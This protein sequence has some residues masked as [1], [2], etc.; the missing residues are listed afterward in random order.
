M[1]EA[2]ELKIT[3]TITGDKQKIAILNLHGY[4]DSNTSPLL[5]ERFLSLDSQTHCFVLDFSDVEYVSSAG[6]GVILGRIKDY[7]DK[8]GDIVFVRMNREV[9]SVYE[10]LELNKVMK[11]FI[12]IQ[13][14]VHYFSGEHK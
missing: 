6:W 1:K 9:A 4:L 8:G 12:T 14:A 3:Q 13:E 7:R 11:H 2:E 5:K 10:L